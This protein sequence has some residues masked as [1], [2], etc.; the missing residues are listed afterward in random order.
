M[1]YN[2]IYFL[3]VVVIK[4]MSQFIIYHNPRCSKSRQTLALLNEHDIKPT[5]VEY[6][7][8]SPSVEILKDLLVKLKMNVQ[9]LV[10]KKEAEYGLLELQDKSE[11]ELLTAMSKHPKLIE[12]PIVIFGNNAVIGRPVENVLKLIES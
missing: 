7:K 8:Q 9:D 11:L 4:Q 1:H 6:L 2:A 12:R 10:R 5:I 3:I